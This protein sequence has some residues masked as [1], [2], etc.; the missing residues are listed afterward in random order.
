MVTK[1]KAFLIS[2]ISALSIVLIHYIAHMFVPKYTTHVVAAVGTIVF[3]SVFLI[4]YFGMTW[5]K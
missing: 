1:Q 5:R 3:I 2:G 4:S